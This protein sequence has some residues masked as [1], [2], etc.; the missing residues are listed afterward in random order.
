MRCFIN[1][2]NKI[3]IFLKFKYIFNISYFIFDSFLKSIYLGKKDRNGNILIFMNFF[4][5]EYRNKF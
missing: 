5:L 2:N 4:F 1:W 3:G